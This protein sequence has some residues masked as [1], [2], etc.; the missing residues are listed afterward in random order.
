MKRGVGRDADRLCDHRDDHHHVWGEG[1][2]GGA[3]GR[4]RGEGGHHGVLRER[5]MKGKD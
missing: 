5:H 4:G 2:G 3:V 1:G